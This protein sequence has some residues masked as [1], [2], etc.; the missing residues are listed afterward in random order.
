[1]N[2]PGGVFDS[3]IIVVGGGVAGLSVALGARGK[4]VTLLSKVPVTPQGAGGSSVWAQGGVAA[5]VGADDSPALHAE[6]TLAAGAGLSVPRVVRVLTEEGPERVFELIALGAE[7]DRADDGGLALGREAA[8]S[9]RRVLHASGDATG[10]EIVR[11]LMAAVQ[12]TPRIGVVGSVEVVDLALDGAPGAGDVR[13]VVGVSETGE[14]QLYRAPAV[15]LATGGLGHLYAHTTNPP[16]NTGDGL[17]IAARAGARLVD[18]EF[19]QFH[20]TALASGIDPMPLLT[21]ALR[22][23][24]AVLVDD[25]GDRFMVAEHELAE[26][27][28]RDIVARAIWRKK[29]GGQQVFLDAREAVGESFPQRFPTVFS[30]CQA[31]GLDPRRELMPVS[32]ATHFHMG[33]IATDIRGRTSLGGL[34]ACGEVASTGAHGANRLAS[35]SLLEGLVY[36]ARVALDIDSCGGAAELADCEDSQCAGSAATPGPTLAAEEEDAKIQELRKLMWKEAGLVRSAAGLERANKGLK[37]LGWWVNSASPR[38]R[39]L[40]TVAQLVSQA[41]SQRLESRGGHFR[42]DFPFPDPAWKRRLFVAL[43]DGVLQEA[44]AW[45]ESSPALAAT[46]GEAAR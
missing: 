11:S 25:R 24:G 7:F 31:Q 22:G 38:L 8:H 43:E 46:S 1:M 13:G 35:N 18:L 6:D 12:A 9:K 41:A 19:V 16:E 14:R 4:K 33:G 28:P 3:D 32:P 42:S 15:V 40:H 21:E 17:A 37:R 39:N 10:A 20:P 27:A 30:L 5:A 29:E 36:G 2:F 26:L 44:P 23:E 34:W 45:P